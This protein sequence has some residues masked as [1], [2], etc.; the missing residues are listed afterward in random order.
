MIRARVKF[1][2]RLAPLSDANHGAVLAAHHVLSELLTDVDVL[3]HFSPD[4][5]V[6]NES[7][8]PFGQLQFDP[9]HAPVV[10]LFV[11]ARGE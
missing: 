8:R 9:D 4:Y 6:S 3:A 11:I 2:T 10:A 5:A 1:C 7:A